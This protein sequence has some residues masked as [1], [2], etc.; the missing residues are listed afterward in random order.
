MRKVVGTII[1]RT[2]AR[3]IVLVCVRKSDFWGKRFIPENFQGENFR[4]YYLR[5]PYTLRN[6]KMTWFGWPSLCFED[7]AAQSEVIG[8]K[9]VVLRKIGG[10]KNQSHSANFRPIALKLIEHGVPILESMFYSFHTF[11]MKV[12]GVT[13]I[14]DI[15]IGSR[16]ISKRGS[17]LADR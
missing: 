17:T 12:V 2:R 9:L 7:T 10:V 1:E 6:Q 15:S 4:G 13:L 11:R 16:R 14:L 3:Y 8:Q 5:N